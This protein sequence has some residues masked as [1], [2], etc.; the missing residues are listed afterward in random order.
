MEEAPITQL[1]N[2]DIPS[3]GIRLSHST[4]ELINTCE[5]KFQIDKLMLDAK[6][7]DFTKDTVFGSAYGIGIA[8]YFCYQDRELAIFELWLAY[9]PK[10]EMDKKTEAKCINCLEASFDVIDKMLEEYEVVEYN[11]R[12]AAELGFCLLSDSRYYFVGYVDLVLK[13][14]ISGQ[15]V[16]LDVKTTG[17]ELE[18]LSPL[19]KNSAQL[20]G[21]SIV[22]DA[23]AGE[24]KATYD[25]IYFVCKTGRGYNPSILVL[26]YRKKLL[27]RLN[28][29]VTLSLDIEKLKMMEAI[30]VYPSRGQGCLKYN[31][32]C[33]YFGSCQFH[34]QDRLKVIPKDDIEYDFYYKIADLITDYSQRVKDYA[35]A[36]SEGFAG[37]DIVAEV[38]E[39]KTY[40]AGGIELLD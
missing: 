5:R 17:L 10:L 24:D 12:P 2:K 31:R 11:G 15:M 6:P 33:K 35:T 16:A 3:Q 28:W 18:D 25:V 30:N 37:F 7:R 22:I 26:T 13:H 32:P 23:I 34:S 39:E 1:G 9:F 29:L 38:E 19:Y 14:R 4:I 20:V 40:S 36:E 21:Y 27:D 8:S